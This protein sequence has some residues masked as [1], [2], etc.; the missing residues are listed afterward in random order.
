MYKLRPLYYQP[1]DLV[2]WKSYFGRY[3]TELRPTLEC[4][5]GPLSATYA[6]DCLKTS[7]RVAAKALHQSYL[8]MVKHRDMMSE[9]ELQLLKEIETKLREVHLIAD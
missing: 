4:T 1:A 2:L 9:G 6:Y 8:E 3:H 7:S 5:E